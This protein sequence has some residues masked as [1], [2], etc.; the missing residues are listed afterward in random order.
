[1]AG[2][3]DHKPLQR[4]AQREHPRHHQRQGGVGVD[5]Q[6]VLEQVDGVERNHE[7]RPMG[8][9]DDVQHPV[10]QGQAQGDQRVH[11][12]GRQAVEHR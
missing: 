1:M 8:E 4:I 6:P 3:V 5:A 2:A 12:A 10:D 7:R 9:I 11:R